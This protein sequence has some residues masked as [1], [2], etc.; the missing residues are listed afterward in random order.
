MSR[1]IS[2]SENGCGDKALNVAVIDYFEI[3]QKWSKLDS[4]K[5]GDIN[6]K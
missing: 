3:Y 2:I 6:V 1:N 5:L 4:P